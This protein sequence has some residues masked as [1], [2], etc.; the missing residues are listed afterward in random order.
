M[1]KTI[2]YSVLFLAAV[3]AAAFILKRN[4]QKNQ[5][6]V[7]IV[8]QIN[9]DVAVRTASVQRENLNGE[10]TVNGTFLPNKQAMISAEM[11]GQV[12]ALYVKEGSYVRAGQTVARLAG[13]KINVN[14]AN[15]K[16][17][18]DM[19]VA[20]LERYEAAYQTGGITALQL[21]Q[22]RQQ[23]KNARA[24]YQSAQLTSGDTNVRSKVSG[25]VN[26]KMIEVGAV[27]GPGTPIVEVVDISVLKLKVEV[28][29]GMVSQLSL[30]NNALIAPSS[31]ADTLSGKITFIAPSSTGALKFPVEITI[32]NPGN[33][34]RAGMYA[35]AIFN[36]TG[37]NNILTIPREAF[38]GSV[39][40]NEV[41]V[42]RDSLAY[43][44]KIQSGV[45]HGD[46]VEVLAGLQEGDV[47]VTSGQIN[48]SDKTKV[49][50]LK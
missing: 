14:V 3:V 25:I 29:E 32:G 22:A 40:D 4:Q 2:F 11:G 48:L 36:R 16:S 42:V 33:K 24:Q 50:I 43:L 6:E 9:P 18:L 7:A 39:N 44:T 5:A 1:K 49:R 8:A 13:E 38:V 20:T 45:N 30:G 21:D 28:D 17:N 46:K 19:A 26:Q 34:L 10:F 47:V 23:V 41:F 35:T 31:T 27:V 12:V 15:A 37:V